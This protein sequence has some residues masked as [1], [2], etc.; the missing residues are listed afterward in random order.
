MEAE[1]GFTVLTENS[2]EDTN[3]PVPAHHNN[4][5]MC[6]LCAAPAKLSFLDISL[7]ADGPQVLKACCKQGFWGLVVSGCLQSSPKNPCILQSRNPKLSLRTRQASLHCRLAVLG[8][9]GCSVGALTLTLK[10][11]TLCAW[12]MKSCARNSPVEP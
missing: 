6:E 10:A 3:M 5:A 7:A 4:P 8:F 11:K 12:D 2:A 1:D 9:E